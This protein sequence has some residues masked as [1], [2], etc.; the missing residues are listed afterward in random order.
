MEKSAAFTLGS[1]W[2]YLKAVTPKA[3]FFE[4]MASKLN[5]DKRLLMAAFN[6]QAIEKTAGWPLALLGAGLLAGPEIY[7]AIRRWG[8]SPYDFKGPG[9]WGR[10]G[11]GP[12]LPNMANIGGLSPKAMSDMMGYGAQMRALGAQNRMIDRMFR[13]QPVF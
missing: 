12:G 13:P 9:G 4:K 1:D 10:P 2:G 6:K 7:R 5:V 11:F 8:T 3:P